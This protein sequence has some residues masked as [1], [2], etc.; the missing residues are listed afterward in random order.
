[1]DTY[2]P[3]RHPGGG[4]GFAPVELHQGGPDALA[5][6]TFALILLL[7]LTVGALLV[8]RLAVGRPR[9]LMRSVA[10]AGPGGPPH[11]PLEVLRWRY[12]R[13]EIGRDEFVQGVSDLS[14][15]VEQPPPG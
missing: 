6:A 8:A 9:R 5:W 11:D 3:F 7:V 1:M 13:G 10:F 12:A 15:T 14:P 4:F 2:P